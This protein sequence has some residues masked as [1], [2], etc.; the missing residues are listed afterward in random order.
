MSQAEWGWKKELGIWVLNRERNWPDMT[1]KNK[2][3]GCQKE[4]KEESE[5][6]PI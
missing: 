2:G 1:G 3:S 6:V 4:G 5:V